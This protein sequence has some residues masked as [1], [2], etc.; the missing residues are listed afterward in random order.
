MEVGATLG[1]GCS[2]ESKFILFASFVERTQ[3]HS[4]KSE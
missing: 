3:W 4:V 1:K 2:I